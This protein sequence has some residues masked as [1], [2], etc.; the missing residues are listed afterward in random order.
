MIAKPFWR[1]VLGTEAAKA[2]AGYGFERLGLK[3]IIALIEA[4]NFASR[5][6]AERASLAFERL[7]GSETCPYSIDAIARGKRQG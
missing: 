6:T 5:R 1:Q 4:G 3:R 7:V 2:M